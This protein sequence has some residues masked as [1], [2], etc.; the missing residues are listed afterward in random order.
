MKTGPVFAV[1]EGSTTM[2]NEIYR[3]V[4][5]YDAYFA[6]RLYEDDWFEA[7]RETREIAA[8]MA[9]RAADSLKYANSKAE[10]TQALKFPRLVTGETVDATFDNQSWTVTI[11]ATGGTFDLTLNDETA[12]A[13]AYNADA[14]TVQTALEGLAS[15]T[16]G[17]TTVTGSAGGPYTIAFE[18]QFATPK[19]GNTLAADGSSLTG[20]GELVTVVVLEDNIPEDFFWG[21]CE[22][23]KSLI[24]N[25]DPAQA[26]ENLVL[27][28]DG[29]GSTR[30]SS[31]RLQTPQRHISHFIASPIAW[32]YFQRYLDPNNNFDIT[33]SN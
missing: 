5:D 18:D 33:R 26:F 29:V 20:N 19:T 9:T 12:S 10:S 17:D 16:A 11:D 28:S 30:V 23:A 31:N 6:K 13:I 14:A 4:D 32:K 15:I 2:A 24:M 3:T 21:V 25:I 1:K 27:N 7:D 8:L 22:E